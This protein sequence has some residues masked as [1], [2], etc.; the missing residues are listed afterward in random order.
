MTTHE[1]S[2]WLRETVSDLLGVDVETVDV[3]APFDALGFDSVLVVRTAGAAADLLGVDVDPVLF[4]E[5]NTIDRLA[6]HLA[7][8][9]AS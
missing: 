6:R 9:K 1:L 5:L 7:T 2:H 8:R 4:F 3:H